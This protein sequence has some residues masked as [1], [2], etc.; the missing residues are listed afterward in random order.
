MAA[1]VPAA[2]V[3]DAEVVWAQRSSARST[4]R[5]YYRYGLG[6]GRSRDARLLGRDL[7]RLLAYALAPLALWWGGP[8][9]AVA[10]TLAVAAY[11]SLPMVRVWRGRSPGGPGR[12]RSAASTAAALALVPAAAAVRDLAKVAGAL[13]GLVGARRR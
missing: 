11:L 5:M 4:A 1:G 8:A 2:L 10:V 12:T 6:S 7:A 13:R 9:G 3:A